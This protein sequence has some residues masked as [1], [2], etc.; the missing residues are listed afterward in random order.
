MPCFRNLA[1]SK[2]HIFLLD[3]YPED[4]SLYPSVENQNEDKMKTLKTALPVALL[5][6]CFSSKAFAGLPGPEI[7]PADGISALALLGGAV[8]IFRGRLKR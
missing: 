6:L 3:L 8:M 2:F 1:L 5:I 7:N 4:A